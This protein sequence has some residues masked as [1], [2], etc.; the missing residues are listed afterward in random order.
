MKIKWKWAHKIFI[1]FIYISFWAKTP[2]SWGRMVDILSEGRK[3][4]SRRQLA[5]SPTRH[6]IKIKKRIGKMSWKRNKRTPV[7]D[8][9]CAGGRSKWTRSEAR[10]ASWKRD[11]I[12][13]MWIEERE[14]KKWEERKVD[15]KHAKK[16]SCSKKQDRLEPKPASLN[17]SQAP[18]HKRRDG[19]KK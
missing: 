2:W 9:R 12:R 16:K 1:L 15:M 10:K 19:E 17:V 11:S 14:R 13:R 8:H 4:E 6:H 7:N 3:N 5:N 18:V